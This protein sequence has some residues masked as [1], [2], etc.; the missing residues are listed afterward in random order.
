MFSSIVAKSLTPS[1]SGQARTGLKPQAVSS[2]AIQSVAAPVSRDTSNLKFAIGI[3]NPSGVDILCVDEGHT[4]TSQ[5]V[6]G[7]A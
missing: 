5:F 3:S 1:M 2:V 6:V 7:L 4:G